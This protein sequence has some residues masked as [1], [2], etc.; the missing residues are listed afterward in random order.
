MTPRACA[1]ALYALF[2]CNSVSAQPFDYEPMGKVFMDT[3]VAEITP[4]NGAPYTVLGGV[5]VFRNVHIKPGVLVRGTGSRPMVWIVLGN[6]TVDGHLR[7]DGADGASVTSVGSANYP[8]PPGLGMCSG[9]DGGRGSPSTTSQSPAGEAG[10]G[11]WQVTGG[12]GG[13][14]SLALVSLCGRGSGGGGGAFATHG[15]PYYKA[16]GLGTS[17]IQQYGFGGFGCVGPSGSPARALP[18]GSVA[19]SPFI[20]ARLDNNFLGV[21]FNV[22]RG[23]FIQGELRQPMGGSGGGAGGD[24][25]AQLG[26]LN[27]TANHKA[28]AGGG[29]GGALVIL[30]AGKITVSGRISAD[31]GNGGGGERGGNNELSGGG[32]G[33][34]GGMIALYSLTGIELYTQGETYA[35]NDF[36]FSL[37]ADGGVGL[38]RGGYG[39]SA[40]NDKYPPPQNGATWDQHPT[41]GM[42]GLGLIQLCVPPGNNADGTNTL[43]DDNIAVIRGGQRLTGVE[44]TRFLGW[45]GYP[46]AQ[47]VWVGD[48]NRPTYNNPP[49]VAGYPAWANSWDD[50]GDMRPAPILL[51]ILP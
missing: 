16:K 1:P 24:L 29:G 49:M 51:P 14:G 50:E 22:Q 43:L 47:G 44:K 10:F 41:G 40:I 39:V 31:G 38:Q 46:N 48:D 15:D 18:G 4:V 36:D 35:N 30:A 17:F 45:R 9:G 32:G 12:G 11:P 7:L 21:G 20:D 5:F 23:N 19:L 6:V 27:W 8:A 2:V 42:G 33:G 25:A 13:G 28:G 26:N 34:A 37:S 3:D